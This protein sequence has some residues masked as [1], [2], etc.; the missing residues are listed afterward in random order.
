M[1]LLTL[2]VPFI[3]DSAFPDVLVIRSMI[4]KSPLHD[5]VME[6]YCQRSRLSN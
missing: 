1:F 4:L 6:I 2:C 5:S 3:T